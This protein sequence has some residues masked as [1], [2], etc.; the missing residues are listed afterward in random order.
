MHMKKQAIV[1]AEERPASGRSSG[2]YVGRDWLFEINR[3]VL[4]FHINL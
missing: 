1:K 2:V 3:T 4:T